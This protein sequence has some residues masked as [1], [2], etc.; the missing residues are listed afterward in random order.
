M[1]RSGFTLIELLVVIGIIVLLA[2]LSVVAIFK[3][4]EAG[5]DSTTDATLS[6]LQNQGLDMEYR[7]VIQRCQIDRNQNRIPADVL[8][9]C[10]ND[11]DRALAVWTTANLKRAFPQTFA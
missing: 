3:V 8:A 4:R 7:E 11:S 6:K 9:Y 5:T 10:E 1:R 2:S